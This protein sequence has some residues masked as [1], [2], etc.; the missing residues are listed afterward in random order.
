MIGGTEREAADQPLAPADGSANLVQRV[1]LRLAAWMER[2][3]PDAFVFALV[4]VLVTGA[5]AAAIGAPPKAIVTSFGHGFWDLITFTLQVSIVAIGGHI[6]ATSPAADRMITRLATVPRNGRQAVAF[7]AAVA[8][9][10]SLLN[11][12]I[13]LIFSALLTRELARRRGDMDYRAA[14][15]A[16]F[17]GVGGVW[18]L[19]LSSA[20]AQMQANAASMPPSLLPISGVLP[21]SETVF[22]PQS[23][24]LAGILV[25]VT[26]V[27]AYLS[28]PDRAHAVT[29]RDLEIDLT[30]ETEPAQVRTRPGD[31]PETSRILPALIAAG[32]A[33]YLALEVSDRG[34][35]IALSDLNTYNFL[36]LMLGLVLHG[37]PRRFLRAATAAVPSVGGVLVQFPF[38]AGVAAI[39]T[40]AAAADGTTLSSTMGHAFSEVASGSLLAPVLAIYSVVLGIFLPSGGGKWIIEAPYVMTAAND[41]HMH[42]GW[43]VQVYNAAE[44]LPN[45]VNPF[46]MLPVLGILGLR[47]RHVVGFTFLQFLVHL[48][49]VLVLVWLLAG[50]LDYMPP[51][52]P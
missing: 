1:A 9:S 47:A 19:G 49:I 26:V 35:W 51:V 7:V 25:V 30:V 52:V 5:G 4:A 32:G 8:T 2:W 12:A 31:W 11:W 36:F 43:T 45:L 22:L 20:P 27:V 34:W 50:T 33:V 21:F 37:T 18:A 40:Q 24:L 10:L 14:G 39:L 46:W 16:S 41:A 44:A 29:A 15:A 38:Y 3:F 28:A 42:L 13:S 23:M 6:V 48:P 17:L